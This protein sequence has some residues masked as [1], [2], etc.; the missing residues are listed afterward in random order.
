[1][2]NEKFTKGNWFVEFNSAG[3]VEVSTYDK[4][5]LCIGVASEDDDC[6]GGPTSVA[7]A[8][9]IA[10]APRMYDEIKNEVEF[11]HSLL[12]NFPV[13]SVESV[14]ICERLELLKSASADARG[15]LWV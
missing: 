9:L 2:N 4:D 8:H 15:E 10:A 13:N 11:L 1:M 3:A 6:C 12:E 7:N 5:Y 14:E